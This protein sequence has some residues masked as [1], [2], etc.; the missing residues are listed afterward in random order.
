MVVACILICCEAG[1]YKD[2][3]SEIK[4]IKGVKRAFGVHGRW[5]GVIEVEAPDL[6][7][8]GEISLKLHGL[9]GVR[10]TE[11]LISF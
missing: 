3:A 5:D 6:K 7:A 8:L 10:A 4:K 2:V 9:E 11:T 1:K